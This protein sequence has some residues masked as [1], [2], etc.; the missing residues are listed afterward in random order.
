[1]R[2][3]IVV[4]ELAY[5][6]PN[7]GSSPYEF[8][9]RGEIWL[10]ET[11]PTGTDI[12][13]PNN[14]GS[15]CADTPKK[16]ITFAHEI[17]APRI[18]GATLSLCLLTQQFTTP[19]INARASCTCRFD[20]SLHLRARRQTA[21]VGATHRYDCNRANTLQYSA[22]TPLPS[23]PATITARQLTTLIA[24]TNRRADRRDTDLYTCR[25]DSRRRYNC[26]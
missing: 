24:T 1:M 6:V 25:C 2:D 8:P 11:I 13:T 20:L 15:W 12:V 18:T 7:L 26:T 14:L 5:H 3:S 9:V 23:K 10:L 4:G 21:L 19:D 17:Q 16:S 22:L